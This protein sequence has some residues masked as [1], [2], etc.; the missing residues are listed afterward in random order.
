LFVAAIVG[1]CGLRDQ[2]GREEGLSIGFENGDFNGDS[3]LNV[4]GAFAGPR[5]RGIGVVRQT[6][7]DGAGLFKDVT[8]CFGA[9]RFLEHHSPSDGFSLRTSLRM[10]QLFLCP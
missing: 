8:H 9:S 6:R 3:V 4:V 5:Y 2:W 1:G 10:Q 7:I